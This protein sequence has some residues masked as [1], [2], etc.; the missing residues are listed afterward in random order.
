MESDEFIN[1]IFLR[2]S[3]NKSSNTRNTNTTNTRN[4]NSIGKINN[5]IK[6]YNTIISIIRKRIINYENI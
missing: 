6:M 3:T 1:N 5:L 4:K 2:I